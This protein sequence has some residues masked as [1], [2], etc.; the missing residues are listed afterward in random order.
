MKTICDTK[1]CYG[2]CACNNVCPT[3]AISMTEDDFGNI[4][5]SIN[6]EKC[7]DCAMCKKVCPAINNSDF[8]LPKYTYAAISKDDYIYSISTSGGAATVMSKC[9]LEKG[10]VVYGAAF[11]NGTSELKHIRV[12]KLDGL[13][14][15]K[16]SK[17]VQSN[18]DLSFR[19]VKED[20]KTKKLVLFIGTPCQIDGLLHYIG[21]DHD[22]LITVNLI[23]HGVPSNRLLTEHIDYVLKN[24]NI[25]NLNISF[26]AENAFKLSVF[27]N[28]KKL[29]ESKFNNDNY[30]LGFM[31]KLFYRDCCYSCKYAQQKRVGDITIGDF[32]G[33][34][35]TKPFPVKANNG[36]SV[37]LVNTDKG[38][39]FFDD[40]GNEFIFQKRELEEAVSGNP[41]LNQPSV[42]NRNY[43][44]FQKLYKKYGFE[45][46]AIKTLSLSKL[47]YKIVFLIRP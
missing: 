13:N 38:K 6:Q 7:I 32:W 23:C 14:K 10:G 19:K 18:I 27:S 26:R 41:Q 45:K 24:K 30:F 25:E 17:Y 35:Q 39:M 33:F 43:K 16:G 44:R 3:N 34:D 46:A 47:L 40:T 31:R 28:D 20:I 42:K 2:C 36:M 37:I 8:N 5:P 11:V 12:D 9:V 22:N 4:I 1:L 29:Y 15:L 21:K